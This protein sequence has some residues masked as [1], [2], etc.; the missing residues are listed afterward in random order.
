M[1]KKLEFLKLEKN[2]GDEINVIILSHRMRLFLLVLGV[3]NI[4]QE[5]KKEKADLLYVYSTGQLERLKK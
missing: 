2:S 3:G 1:I 4:R 5:G